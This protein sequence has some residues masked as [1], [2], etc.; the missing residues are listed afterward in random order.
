MVRDFFKS[1][2]ISL[3]GASLK[4]LSKAEEIELAKRAANGDKQARETLIRT[5]IRYALSYAK[6]FYGHGLSNEEVEEEAGSV[7]NNY[8]PARTFPCIFYSRSKV[9]LIL[10]FTSGS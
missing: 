3:Y 10:P 8:L 7:E 9:I 2:G 1:K 4:P 5:N 6:T